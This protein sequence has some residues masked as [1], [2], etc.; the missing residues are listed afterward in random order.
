MWL[1]FYSKS[2]QKDSYYVIYFHCTIL[3][4]IVWTLLKMI[5]KYFLQFR[6][7]VFNSFLLKRIILVSSRKCWNLWKEKNVSQ[8]AGC[9]D[10]KSCFYFC[11]WHVVCLHCYR[12]RHDKIH[13]QQR[14]PF[15]FCPRQKG[16]QKF[17][18]NLE[19][20]LWPHTAIIWNA[21]MVKVAQGASEK[22][23]FATCIPQQLE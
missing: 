16:K 15:N 22:Q 8:P 6:G 10:W 14:L 1:P 9:G 12:K 11:L 2:S 19:I 7:M 4:Y 23:D 20:Q 3:G 21:T 18:L 13:S 5:P 17:S